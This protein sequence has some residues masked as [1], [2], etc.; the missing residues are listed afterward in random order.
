MK[1]YIV[2]LTEDE[3]KSLGELTSKGKHKSQKILDALI[4][5]GCDEGRFQTK[6]STN[7]EIASVLNTS[8]RK[9]DRVKKRFIEEGLDVALHGRKGSR[10]YAKK[11]DGDFEAYLIALSCSEPPEGF[12]RWSLRLLADKVV[13][14]D[15][16]GSISHEA[17]RR[18]LKKTKLNLGDTRGG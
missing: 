17:V 1:K 14:L 18:V 9:I 4:L 8:M 11:A 3:R 16:I 12:A 7:E 6:R 10:I 13:E 15:Y 5:L 2:T